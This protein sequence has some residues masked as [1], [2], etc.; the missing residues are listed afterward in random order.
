MCVCIL[1]IIEVLVLGNV[2]WGGRGSACSIISI[3]RG[4]T[5]VR[6]VAHLHTKFLSQNFFN[7]IHFGF[8]ITLYTL[9]FTLHLNTLCNEFTLIELSQQSESKS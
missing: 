9:H 7:F 1:C 4:S 2:L 5:E 3:S 8:C 6:G